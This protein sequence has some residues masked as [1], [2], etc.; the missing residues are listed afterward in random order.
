MTPSQNLISQPVCIIG[1]LCV[2]LIIRNVPAMP[3]W[4]QEVLGTSH[5][6]VSSGQTGYTA[7]ALSRLGISTS[8]IGS[9]GEDSNGRQV[10][11]DLNSYGIDTSGVI[12]IKDG[13][14]GISVAIVRNDGERAF[15]STLGCSLDFNEQMVLEKWD[16]PASA[17]IVCLVGLFNIPNLTLESAAS[18]LGKARQ[19]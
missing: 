10:I 5:A 4:G 17:S 8:V 7:F 13:L 9:V 2:D 1:N 15:V 16:I 18:L 11:A 6:L 19:A 14:T 3:V 12:V